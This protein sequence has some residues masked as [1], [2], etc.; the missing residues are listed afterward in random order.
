MIGTLLIPA[1]NSSRQKIERPIIQEE[2]CDLGWSQTIEG[3][4]HSFSIDGFTQTMISVSPTNYPIS[5]LYRLLILQNDYDCGLLIEKN[6]NKPDNRP[7]K[8]SNPIQQPLSQDQ[9][10]NMLPTKILEMIMQHT[11]KK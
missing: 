1:I 2:Y 10:K 7:R 6:Q 4:E 8:S 11:N 9:N 3:P 5:I